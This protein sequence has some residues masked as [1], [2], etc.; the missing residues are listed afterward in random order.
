MTYI[1]KAMAEIPDKDLARSVV[2][3]EV[4]SENREELETLMQLRGITY[5]SPGYT[6][7]ARQFCDNKLRDLKLQ[8]A[9]AASL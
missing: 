8:Q 6:A 1:E 7:F 5:D 2:N 9:F 3:A 4:L